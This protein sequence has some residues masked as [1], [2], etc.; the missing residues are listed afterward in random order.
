MVA[1]MRSCA[2]VLASMLLFSAACGDIKGGAS[3]AAPE[4]DAAQPDAAPPGPCDPGGNPTP[5]QAYQC[6]IEGACTLVTSCLPIFTVEACVN[7]DLELFD[8]D[9][10]RVHRAILLD[11]IERGTVEFHPGEVAACYATLT[12]FA[13]ANLYEKLIDDFAIDRICPG[14]FT[15]TVAMDGACFTNLECE[16]PGS[17]CNKTGECADPFCCPGTCVIPAGIDGSCAANPCEPGA[18]CVEGLCRPGDA[19][20]P[21]SSSSQCDIGLWCSAGTCQAELESGAAC[22]VFEQC[23]GPEV[24]LIPPGGKSGTC[25][26]IDQ[27]DA[28]CDESC[29]GM[30]CVQP[31]AS[32]LGTCTPLLDEE[33]ADCADFYCAAD[34][35]CSPATNQCDPRGDVGDPCSNEDG[36]R[37]K[38]HLFCDNVITGEATGHCSAPQPDNERCTQDVHC[39]SG[40]CVGDL[41]A[42]CAPYPG[43]YE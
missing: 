6:M 7:S 30:V 12:E 33:G 19:D 21:C 20:S 2:G 38:L 4:P 3:D 23:P 18:Y 10:S 42:T 5:D 39:Q 13:C 35:E 24:C 31:D 14:V 29:F 26:R 40:V 43:C 11:A 36:N 16:S 9:S 34:F 25:A 37:C 41:D 1:T 28:A 22:T 32:Q 8:V 15:G 27:P 17:V